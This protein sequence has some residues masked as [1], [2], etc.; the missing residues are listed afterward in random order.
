MDLEYI[1]YDHKFLT[2]RTLKIN[3]VGRLQVC[4]LV[5]VQHPSLQPANEV[6]EIASKDLFMSNP[7]PELSDG[8]HSGVIGCRTQI[9]H[10]FPR[11]V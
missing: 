4:C 7:K 3:I 1:I 8:T 9:I 6:D 2:N 5:P 11:E 10:A